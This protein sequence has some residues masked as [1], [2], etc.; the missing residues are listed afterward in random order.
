[1]GPD[2]RE[3]DD[4][5]GERGADLRIDVREI[6]SELRKTRRPA[7][8]GDAFAQGRPTLQEIRERF[9]VV[10]EDRLDA[11]VVDDEVEVRPV[12]GGLRDVLG[13]AALW[14]VIQGGRQRREAL[15]DTDIAGG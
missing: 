9:R 8:V 6:A 14:P 12:A 7:D 11:R 10:E 3:R 13:V 15:V 4:G 2:G 1:M 5:R